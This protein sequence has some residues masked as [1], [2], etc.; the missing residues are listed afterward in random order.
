MAQRDY[1]PVQSCTASDFRSRCW[2]PQ[3]Y[4]HSKAGM[5]FSVW[6]KDPLLVLGIRTLRGAMTS[7]GLK[8]VEPVFALSLAYVRLP[9]TGQTVGTSLMFL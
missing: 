7:L 2:S 1:C 4:V 6:H 9:D 5:L 3:Q 8:M